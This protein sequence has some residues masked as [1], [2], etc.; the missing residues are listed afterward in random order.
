MKKSWWWRN[1]L[2]LTLLF[3][4]LQCNSQDPFVVPDDQ[5]HHIL[6][7]SYKENLFQ[8]RNLPSD[9]L[10]Y[11]NVVCKRLGEFS[12][13]YGYKPTR[14]FYVFIGFDLLKYD[15]RLDSSVVDI[16]SPITLVVGDRYY[17]VSAFNV[18]IGII[19][20]VR[21]KGP[22]YLGGTL[23]INYSK[24]WIT[25]GEYQYFNGHTDTFKTRNHNPGTL[26]FRSTVFLEAKLVPAISISVFF[27][28]AETITN[29]R[30]DY[31][32]NLRYG[33]LGLGLNYYIKGRPINRQRTGNQD[34]PTG[35]Y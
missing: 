5:F 12:F 9:N 2:S 8:L 18:P 23:E 22:F 13:R 3:L 19:G 10:R 20:S 35:S 31:E 27:Q 34:K 33:G 7:A 1:S 30:Q 26:R 25:Y 17:K 21:I 6:S 15:Y 28:Y 14:G 4:S 32:F 29:P 11:A 16:L 24:K